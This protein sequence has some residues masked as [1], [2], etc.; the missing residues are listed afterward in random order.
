MT[1]LRWVAAC[2]LMCV[3]LAGAAADWIAPHSYA[4]QF[5]DRPMEAPSRDHLL[6]TDELGRDRFSRLLYAT[7]VSTT[8]PVLAA[9]LATAV[10]ACVGIATGY[11]G[12]WLD[13]SAS[14]IVD[15]ALCLP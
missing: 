4:T 3:V 7:R 1:Y 15:L 11:V 13:V 6:G 9:L 5:R 12:G 14:L 2:M 10:A 8:L